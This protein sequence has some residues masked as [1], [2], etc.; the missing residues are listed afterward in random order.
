MFTKIKDFADKYNISIT[1]V[2]T[3]VVISTLFGECA[4]DYTTGD[5]SIETSPV[6]IV[7]KLKDVEEDS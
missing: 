4:V 3:A 7:E 2:G 1:I 5:V 6:E